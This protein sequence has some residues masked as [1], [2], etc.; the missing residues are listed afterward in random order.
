MKFDTLIMVDVFKV[1]SLEVMQK[2]KYFGVDS[3]DK[4][5]VLYQKLRSFMVVGLSMHLMT[6]HSLLFVPPHKLE[7][8]GTFVS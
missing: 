2:L 7:I 1:H 8:T 5:R 3:H 4:S 6:T